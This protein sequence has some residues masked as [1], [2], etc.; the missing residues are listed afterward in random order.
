[1]RFG[2]VPLDQ[3]EG[4]LLA[5]S[6]HLGDKRLRKGALLTASD[7]SDIRAAGIEEVTVARLDPGDL[8]ENAAAARLAAAMVPDPDAARLRL[9]RAS[10]GRVNIYGTGPG[11]LDLDVAA[12]EA[13]NRLDPSVSIATLPPF[14]PTRERAMVATVKLITYGVAEEIVTQ[15]EQLLRGA[16]R[17]RP[18]VLRHAVLIETDIGKG[19]GKGAGAIRDRLASL[20]MTMDGPRV[21]SH[22]TKDI[23]DAI[24]TAGETDLVLILT[25][26][27]TSDTH[28]VAP[29]ALREAGGQVTRFGM[30]VDPGNLLFLG[31][32]GATP[33]IGLP[34]CVR[35]PAL[36]GADFV[37]ERVACGIDVGV[38]D[39]A[40]MGVGGL[41]KESPARPHPR[42]RR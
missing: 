18:V 28:D 27:A 13:A 32:I 37:L 2:P 23:A 5:H 42:E 9:T 3:A 12:I 22:R 21:V 36:N 38:D 25:A 31:D 35:S 16:M 6:L 7:L 20:G 34:G 40:A 11:V 17:A 8:D 29:Q 39:I 19:P 26:S 24:A 15:G 30:P 33:V 41:L 1:M 4:T 10:T 14:A